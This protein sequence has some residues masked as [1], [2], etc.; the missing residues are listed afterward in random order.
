MALGCLIPRGVALSLLAS[1]I[2]IPTAAQ[3]APEDLPVR[4]VSRVQGEAIVQAAWELRKG[5]DPKPDC[6]HFVYAI[7]QQAGLD[8][9]YASSAEMFS[10]IPGFKRVQ[11]SQAGD[12]VVWPGHVGII[13]DPAE[14]TFYSSVIKGYA[15]EDYRS[16]YWKRR[17]PPRFY[18]YLISDA[19]SAKLHMRSEAAPVAATA[20][21]KLAPSQRETSPATREVAQAP[22]VVSEDA[23]EADDDDTAEPEPVT[24]AK[25]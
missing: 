17:G 15:L 9:N 12:L 14:H 22:R 23:G 1:S 19:Q 16:H 11:K 5:L 2:C 25:T 21:R 24:A 6:S 7:Y 13:V 10:G 8:Y 3:S 20:L 18:R 4:P